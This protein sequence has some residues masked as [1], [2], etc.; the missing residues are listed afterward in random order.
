MKRAT[1]ISLLGALAAHGAITFNGSN[2]GARSI[3]SCS[4]T[5]NTLTI[6]AWIYPV[7]VTAG[8]F[9]VVVLKSSST[10]GYYAGLWCFG[11]EVRGY[12]SGGPQAFASSA[13]LT[14]NAWQHIAMTKSSSS[15]RVVWYAGTARAT[16]SNDHT[17][18]S[19]VRTNV[20]VSTY[21]TSG[22]GSYVF[23]GRIA[24]V[25]IWNVTLTAGEIEGLAAGLSPLR[26]RPASLVFYGP[27]I[28]ASSN[29]NHIGQALTFTNNP[30]P[31][32]HP[33]V[34]R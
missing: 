7:T 22:A 5:S 29:L 12:D 24:E 30:P 8:Q 26:V 25:G 1:V 28:G 15:N 19:G 18:A 32:D 2:Q 16:N 31:S 9:R 11:T 4:D 3:G 20:L 33:R 21:D 14:T 6:A 13:V 27:L 23:D 17:S 34:Y 10:A